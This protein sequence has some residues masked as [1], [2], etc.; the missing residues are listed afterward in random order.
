[1]KHKQ[2]SQKGFTLVELL[3]ATAVFSMVLI[4]FLT[5]LMGVSQLF[6]KGVNLS[7]TQGAARN[8][9]QT[10][11]DDIQ[12]SKEAP[13]FHT[14][15]FCIANYRYSFKL[16]VQVDS[17]L[18]NDYGLVR[19]K[20]SVCKAPDTVPPDNV[21]AA[22]LQPINFGTAEKLLDPGMQLNDMSIKPL[23]GAVS[24][25]ILIVYYGANKGVFTS[26]IA[27]N[28]DPSSPSYNAYQATD[29]QCTGSPSSSQFCA[30]AKYQT[31]IL[32]NF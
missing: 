3:I 15:Y 18:P 19:E 30:T 21:P 23:N 29:A 6:Y 5:A 24:A 8:V 11:A 7:N 31:T 32:Q 1:M 10:I 20:V 13:D 27:S 26:Q 9:I 4:V 22:Q 25:K 17:G 16:G 2:L 14:D 12:F 28:N